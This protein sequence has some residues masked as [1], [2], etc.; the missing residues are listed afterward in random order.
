M[1]VRFCHQQVLLHLVHLG[2]VRQ[3]SRCGA[4]GRRRTSR[5]N[6]ETALGCIGD[7]P[8]THYQKASVFAITR[9]LSHRLANRGRIIEKYLP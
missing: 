6:V 4:T 9:A 8:A 5:R 1:Q 3:R 7:V 2:N